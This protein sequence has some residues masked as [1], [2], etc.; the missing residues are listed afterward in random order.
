LKLEEKLDEFSENLE[1]EKE[2]CEIAE[3]EQ[4]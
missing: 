3:T 4:N 2:K 1:V